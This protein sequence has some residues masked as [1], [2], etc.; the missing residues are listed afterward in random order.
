MVARY[1]SWTRTGY[2][3]ASRKCDYDLIADYVYAKTRN[4]LKTTIENVV[5]KIVMSYE[6]EFSDTGY[7][8]I[9]NSDRSKRI[10]IEDI[11]EYIR[12]NG[13]STFDY[14]D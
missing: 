4:R 13:L 8:K 2:I 10:N 5:R 6:E 1:D 3:P 7:Y 11:K 14:Y 9:P 12:D